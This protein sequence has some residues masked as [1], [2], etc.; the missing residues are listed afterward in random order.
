MMVPERILSF[1]KSSIKRFITGIFL[2]S[3]VHFRNALISTIIL[4]CGEYSSGAQEM[5]NGRVSIVLSLRESKVYFIDSF[6]HRGSRMTE[7]I[8]E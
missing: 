6:G 8:I 4:V 2:S 5:G 3:I 7:L 1:S